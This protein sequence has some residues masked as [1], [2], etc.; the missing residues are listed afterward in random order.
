MTHLMDQRRGNAAADHS[1][2]RHF[3]DRHRIMAPAGKPCPGPPYRR[4]DPAIEITND[5][6]S[7]VIPPM[8]AQGIRRNYVESRKPY[9]RLVLAALSNHVVK[10]IE[11]REH[12][13]EAE[14]QHGESSLRFF[15]LSPITLRRPQ[16]LEK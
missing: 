4:A 6:R 3:D 5:G 11:L 9:T 7:L 8:Q 14:A 1:F 12:G 2:P 13:V 10:Q 16:P 15:R